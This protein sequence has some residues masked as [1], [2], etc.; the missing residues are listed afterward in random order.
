VQHL[1]SVRSKEAWVGDA[2]ANLVGKAVTALRS[3][4]RC[5]VKPLTQKR[6]TSAKG[7]ISVLSATLM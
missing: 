3:A 5:R 7:A 6:G 4:P 2:A 1:P